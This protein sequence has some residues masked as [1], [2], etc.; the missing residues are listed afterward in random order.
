VRSALPAQRPAPNGERA[1]ALGAVRVGAILAVP[2]LIAGWLIGATA[3]LVT[4]A[5]ALGFLVLNLAGGAELLG[6]AKTRGMGTVIGVLFGGFLAKIVA[7]GVALVTLR[8]LEVVN[9][10]A[11]ALTVVV[12]LIAL[13]GYA[14]VVASRHKEL[15]WVVDRREQG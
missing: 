13:L 11:L 9:G 7:L 14:V 15:W 2:L 4:A 1:L 10:E 12:G 6:W 8:P 5:V 3:G